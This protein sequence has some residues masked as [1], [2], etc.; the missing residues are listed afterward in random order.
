M[1]FSTDVS[2]LLV[3]LLLDSIQRLAARIRSKSMLISCRM[4]SAARVPPAQ[5]RAR[6]PPMSQFPADPSEAPGRSVQLASGVPPPLS[7][8]LLGQVVASRSLTPYGPVKPSRSQIEAPDATG[9][10]QMRRGQANAG[11]YEAQPEEKPG[12]QQ[13]RRSPEEANV[14]KLRAFAQ[15]GDD[16]GG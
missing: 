13:K 15:E 5:V 4:I 9:A 6:R 14:R 2:R 10:V 7:C 12:L 16:L 8:V 11:K 3:S 1:V